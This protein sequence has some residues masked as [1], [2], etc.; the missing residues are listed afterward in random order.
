MP[1]VL[2]SH[3]DGPALP[4]SAERETALI[5]QQIRRTQGET[6]KDIGNSAFVLLMTQVMHCY[7]PSATGNP[8]LKGS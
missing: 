8:S 7:A 1:L 2:I 3:D 5:F 6:G 4:E